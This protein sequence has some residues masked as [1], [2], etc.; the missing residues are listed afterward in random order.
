MHQSDWVELDTS[1]L[2]LQMAKSPEDVAK[3]D[4]PRSAPWFACFKGPDGGDVTYFIFTEQKVLCS[5]QS[6]SKAIMLW[7]V[8]HYIFNLEYCKQIKEVALFFQEFV[9]GLPDRRKKNC[10]LLNCNQ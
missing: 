8:S 4:P 1:P 2:L 10:H 7:F 3:S 5:V 9:L 6:F